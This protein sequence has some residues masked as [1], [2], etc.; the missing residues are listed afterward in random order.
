MNAAMRRST[1]NAEGTPVVPGA[2]LTG[3]F[4][5][6]FFPLK[7]CMVA[8]QMAML[9]ITATVAAKQQRERD[10]ADALSVH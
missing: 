7:I 3:T 4:T 8:S 1:G 5:E 2:S 10:G 9:S 6:P